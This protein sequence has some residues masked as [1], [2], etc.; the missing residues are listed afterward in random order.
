MEAL[1]IVFVIEVLRESVLRL[2]KA[3]SP[4]IGT[5]GGIVVGTAV[6]KAGLV[7]PQMNNL[8]SVELL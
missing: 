6:V 4:T 8:N 1:L 2:P 5:V 7:S 3:L